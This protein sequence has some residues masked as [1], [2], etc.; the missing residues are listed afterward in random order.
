MLWDYYRY[1]LDKKHLE[2][3]YPIIEGSARF[4]KESLVECDGKLIFP[5]T[6]SPENNYIEN[7]EMMPIDKS[8]AMTQEI[9][10]GLFLAV[11]EAQEI[12]GL[13]NTY[14]ELVP[15]LKKPGICKNGELCEWH[16]EHEVW[17][18]HHRHVSHLYGLFPANLFDEKEREAAKKVLESRGDGGTGW[19]LAW[20]I[21]FWARLRDGEHAY[22][23]LKNQLSIVPVKKDEII[24]DKGGSFPNLLCAHPPFQIDGNFGAAS[25]I[26]EMLVQTD[27]NGKAELLPAVPKIWKNG[28]VKNI[29]IPGNKSISFAWENGNIIKNSIKEK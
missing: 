16:E 28:I 17:D 4:Y 21:N 19:S 26:I 23:L 12:L 13:E 2:Q 7:G 25:G 14:S 20:K 9:I 18:P 6:T 29:R 8:T 22:Q 11:G 10:T 1:T 3:I 24:M 15:K 5:L 27:E